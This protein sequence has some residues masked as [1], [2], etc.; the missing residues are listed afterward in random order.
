M[1]HQ[2]RSV[3]WFALIVVIGLVS[4]FAY[5]LLIKGIIDFRTLGLAMLILIAGGIWEQ[6]YVPETPDEGPMSQVH[7]TGDKDDVANKAD[8]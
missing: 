4:Q 6:L 5:E 3:L 1:N 2:D 8:T 7:E